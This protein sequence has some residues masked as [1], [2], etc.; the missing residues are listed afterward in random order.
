MAAIE[1]MLQVDSTKYHFLWDGPLSYEYSLSP[2]RA[3]MQ[4]L[5][6]CI[7]CVPRRIYQGIVL[8]GKSPYRDSMDLV[9]FLRRSA[10]GDDHVGQ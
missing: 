10:L 9:E 6:I 2:M 4:E 3:V 5:G 8:W 1:S 7:A